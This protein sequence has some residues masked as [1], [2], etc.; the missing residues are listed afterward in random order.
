MFGFN[1]LDDCSAESVLEFS[2]AP[3]ENG[4]V[5]D[6]SVAA[7]SRGPVG[8]KLRPRREARPSLAMTDVD[9]NIADYQSVRKLDGGETA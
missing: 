8:I 9:R 4:A 3:F 5:D 7:P 2:A 6:F 1:R